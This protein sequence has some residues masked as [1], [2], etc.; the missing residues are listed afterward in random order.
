[1]LIAISLEP[2][3]VLVIEVDESANRTLKSKAAGMS[4]IAKHILLR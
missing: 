2:G 3:R 1:M 4:S